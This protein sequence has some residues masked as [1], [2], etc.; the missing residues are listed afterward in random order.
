M[1]GVPEGHIESIREE[2]ATLVNNLDDEAKVETM[3]PP[4]MRVEQ[5][6]AQH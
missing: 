3:A 4:H 6:K 5:L 2:E 1:T